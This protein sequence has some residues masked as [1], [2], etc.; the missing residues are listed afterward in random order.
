MA[1]P[2]RNQ[3]V[4]QW[5][6]RQRNGRKGEPKE[7]SVS[8]LG[9]AFNIVLTKTSQKVQGFAFLAGKAGFIAFCVTQKVS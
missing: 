2:L 9:N 5:T 4:R 3:E 6:R 7:R 1:T 8:V